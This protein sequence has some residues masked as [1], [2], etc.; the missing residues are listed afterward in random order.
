MWI[1]TPT[2]KA[3][4]RIYGSGCA[5]H[6]LNL[7]LTFKLYKILEVSVCSKLSEDGIRGFLSFLAIVQKELLRDVSSK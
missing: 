2:L 5:I 4:G 7:L 6:I 3:V 1:I